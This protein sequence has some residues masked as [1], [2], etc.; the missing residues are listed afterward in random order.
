MTKV[1]ADHL[2]VMLGQGIRVATNQVSFS[3]LDR[4]AA[5][6]LTAL[7][8]ARGVRLLAYGTLGGGLISEQWVGAP[9]PA[10]DAITDWSRIKYRRFIEAIGGW[11][12]FQ[13][14]LDALATI[15]GR[16]G[17]S[18]ANVATRWVLDQPAVAAVIVRARLGE[19]GHR[20]DNRRVFDLALAA[21]DRAELDAALR[22]TRRVPGDCGDEYRRHPT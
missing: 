10:A 8:L 11:A 19:R 21:R 14:V 3:V 18:I 17:V 16:H 5:E 20:A 1:D 7:C 15:A 22:S 6:D 9:D 4:R 2:H 13:R 12:A